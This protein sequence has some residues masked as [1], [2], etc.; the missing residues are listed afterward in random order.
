MK[1][2][3]KTLRLS[4]A[5]GV[6]LA[7]PSLQVYADFTT[8][9]RVETPPFAG[10]ESADDAA[11]WLHPTDPAQSVI[12]GNN[13]DVTDPNWGLHVYDLSGGRL[14]SVTGSKQNNIN[15]RYGFPLGGTTVD[16]IASTNRTEKTID[17]FTI[18]PSARTLT[19]VGSVPSGFA[20]P[21]GL[22]LWND[23][24]HNKLY[25]FISDDDDD[26]SIR[27]FEL[28]D[29]GGSVQGTLV[30]WWEV[31]SLTEGLVVDD[32]RGSLF[33]GEEDVGI[34][35]YDAASTA[36]TGTGDRTAVGQNPGE[37]M[38]HDV[39]GLT[40]FD[41]RDA[42]NRQGYLLASEQ[43]NNSFAIL[44]RYDQ[45][46]DGI[47][48]EYLGR[49]SVGAGHGIDGVSDTDGIAVISTAL[50]GTFPEG[51]FV[52]QDG[53]DDS[54]GQNHKFVSWADVVAA[55]AD[56]DPSLTLFTDPDFDPR[57]PIPEPASLVLLAVGGLCLLIYRRCRRARPW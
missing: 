53:H 17:F 3:L 38:A 35:R 12:I 39:E 42:N 34:W 56:D 37:V 19:S 10:S 29:E 24:A 43:G 26:G 52:A 25:V 44:E 2:L 11:I 31:G 13:K 32:L 36:G 49:F 27:Q 47:L 15:V 46:G 48:Y 7:V 14:S 28:F 22:A 57:A 51:L 50:D 1:I 16:I 20:D 45:D 4:L 9:P 21:Y 8:S 30:R 5:A 6:V 54:G 55:A 40:I 23:W 18:D 41:V 33:V